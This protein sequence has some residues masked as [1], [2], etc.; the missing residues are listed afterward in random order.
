MPYLLINAGNIS[1]SVKKEVRLFWLL[2]CDFIVTTYANTTIALI[3]NNRCYHLCK[4]HWFYDSPEFK[5]LN[6]FTITC[7]YCFGPA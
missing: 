7:V 3:R 2:Y 4:Q 1:Q 6:L 5:A